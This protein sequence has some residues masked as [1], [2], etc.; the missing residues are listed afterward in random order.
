MPRS[1]C[2]ETRPV[3]VEA[4]CAFGGVGRRVEDDAALVVDLPPP[5]LVPL[6]LELPDQLLEIAGARAA[7]AA[8]DSPESPRRG[9]AAGVVS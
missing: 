2:G 1:S 9:A 7:S 4:P 6:P 5:L 8:E 3:D